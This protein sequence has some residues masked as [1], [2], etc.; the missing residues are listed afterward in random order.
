MEKVELSSVN[1]HLFEIGS[2]FLNSIIYLP[3]SF[4]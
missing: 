2:L 4:I 3:V 1:T